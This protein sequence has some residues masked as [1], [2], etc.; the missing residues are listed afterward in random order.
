M[1]A[2][3]AAVAFDPA[4]QADGVADLLGPDWDTRPGDWGTDSRFLLH[5]DG[6]RVRLYAGAGD[7]RLHVAG[8][9]PADTGGVRP[10]TDGLDGGGITLAVTSTPQ[11]VAAEITRRLLPA[12]TAAFAT[13]RLRLAELLAAEE[14]RERAAGRIAAIPGVSKP[15]RSPW[16][17]SL[18][19]AYH[20]HWDGPVVRTAYPPAASARVAVDA[21]RQTA[22]VKVSVEM[23]GLTVEQAEAVLRLVT[24]WPA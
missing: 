22:E 24:A 8:L 6:Y 20:A 4:V 18:E 1:H 7:G 13:Y 14:A 9:L 21:D 15:A 3:K 17:N 2:Q 10:D 12:L 16:R 19:T 11:R 5:R 23:S